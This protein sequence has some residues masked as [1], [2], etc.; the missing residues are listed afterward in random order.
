MLRK[1]AI[2]SV[3][4]VAFVGFFLN[5]N[6]SKVAAATGITVNIHPQQVRNTIAHGIYSQFL[7]HIY[8]SADNGLWGEMI[9]NRSFEDPLHLPGGQSVRTGSDIR[10][11]SLA[12][13]VRKAIGLSTWNHYQVALDVKKLGGS[14]G[15][16]I[17]LYS[18]DAGHWC[19]LNLGG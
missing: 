9:W 5:S 16:M 17:Y 12:A 18:H 13:N 2:L 19:D 10:Q 1:T 7:E 8:H 3:M 11:L 15:F 4:V 14:E 6:I